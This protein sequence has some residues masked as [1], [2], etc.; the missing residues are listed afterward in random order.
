M[1]TTATSI[2]SWSCHLGQTFRTDSLKLIKVHGLP[3]VATPSPWPPRPP[4]QAMTYVTLVKLSWHTQ[5]NVWSSHGSPWPPRC[6][7][8]INIVAMATKATS[9]NHAPRNKLSGQTLGDAWNSHRTSWPLRCNISP[10]GPW[11]PLLLIMPPGDWNSRYL[12]KW[13]GIKAGNSVQRCPNNEW[14][15]P[16]PRTMPWEPWTHVWSSNIPL[17]LSPYFVPGDINNSWW[18]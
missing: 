10:W 1:A 8:S 9:I 5:G 12:G 3:S 6:S 2:S 11:P 7:Y 15:P 4:P 13:S 14:W 16:W 17:D 18:P